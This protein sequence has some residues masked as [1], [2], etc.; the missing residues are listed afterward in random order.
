MSKIPAEY[1]QLILI[2]SSFANVFIEAKTIKKAKIIESRLETAKI[3]KEAI[4]KA[5]RTPEAFIQASATGIYGYESNEILTE[6]S[7]RQ[8]NLNDT[9][10]IVESDIQKVHVSEYGIY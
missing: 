9:L 8:I 10:Q 6:D 5:N 3:L 4:E 2:G 7:S 1:S